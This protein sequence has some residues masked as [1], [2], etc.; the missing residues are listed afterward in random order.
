MFKI[1]TLVSTVIKAG[2]IERVE[3]FFIADETG[4]PVTGKTHKAREAAEG[5]L[6][7]MKHLEEGMSF[8]KAVFPELGD[9]ALK[10]KANVVAEYLAWVE[11]G[12]LVKAEAAVAEEVAVETEVVAEEEGEEV[13]F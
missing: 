12:R 6:A 1:E 4:A 3:T 10:G 7:G 2:A 13:E 8:A 11:G 9:K 5:E